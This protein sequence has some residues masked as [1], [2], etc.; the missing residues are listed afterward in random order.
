MADLH[1]LGR[2]AGPRGAA[3]LLDR[4]GLA[5]AA[6]QDGGHLLRR[7]AAAARPGHDPDRDARG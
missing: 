5:D 3:A 7:D 4:F 6:R 2:A 1:H